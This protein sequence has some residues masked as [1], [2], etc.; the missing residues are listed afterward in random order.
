LGVVLLELVVVV[1]EEEKESFL[2][3]AGLEV[4]L[5]MNL[6]SGMLMVLHQAA[7]LGILALC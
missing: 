2:L 3:L 6:L 7:A 5:S 1:Q 4:V